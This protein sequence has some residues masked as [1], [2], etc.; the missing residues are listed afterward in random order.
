[1]EEVSHYSPETFVQVYDKIKQMILNKTF[2]SANWISLVVMAME[3]VEALPKLKG[4]EK[5]NLVVDLVTR[6]VQ[7]VPMPEHDRILLT[8]LLASSL[9]PIIDT[10]VQGS[11]GQLAINVVQDAHDATKKCLARCKKQ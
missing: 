6:L 8:S 10:I 2:T 4:V 1:M 11:L 9:P 3:L 5:R 7:E